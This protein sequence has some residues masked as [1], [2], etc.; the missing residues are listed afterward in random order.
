[1]TSVRPKMLQSLTNSFKRTRAERP[2]GAYMQGR[3]S[4]PGPSS[5]AMRRRSTPKPP[6]SSM[7]EQRESLKEALTTAM[8]ARRYGDALD[9]ILGLITLDEADP[10]WPHKYGDVLRSLRRTSEAAAAYRRAARRYEAAGFPVR[11]NAMYRLAV[12]LQGESDLNPSDD[13]SGP[14]LRSDLSV[15]V[16]DEQLKG[17][18]VS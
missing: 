14:Q 8:N 6:A 5:P 18:R 9:H 16:T 11:A 13:E 7:N 17:R 1:M 2:S 4:R 15:P 12:E 10:R 3:S